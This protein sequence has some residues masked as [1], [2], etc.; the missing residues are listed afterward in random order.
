MCRWLCSVSLLSFICVSEALPA[1]SHA[2]GKH[3]MAI[4]PDS[5]NTI[6]ALNSVGSAELMRRHDKSEARGSASDLRAIAE[7][8]EACRQANERSERKASTQM[9]NPILH[10]APVLDPNDGQDPC[11][12]LSKAM[13]PATLYKHVV[14]RDVDG[15]KTQVPDPALSTEEEQEE[16]SSYQDSGIWKIFLIFI[17][18]VTLCVLSG[19]ALQRRA[20]D[21]KV[22][23]MRKEREKEALA[24]QEEEAQNA[25]NKGGEAAT[26]STEQATAS[27]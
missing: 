8:Q 21:S 1:E 16:A 19:I 9:G 24:A 12:K 13:N 22:E 11:A 15:T 4:A 17:V 7:L 3:S 5:T 26:S 25:L 10:S 27:S 23:K 18:V 14:V 6:V 2:I 20:A